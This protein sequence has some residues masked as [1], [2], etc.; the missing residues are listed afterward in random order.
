MKKKETDTASAAFVAGAGG[1][2]GSGPEAPKLI[3]LAE[4]GR[5]LGVDPT[6]VLRWAKAGRGGLRAFQF[7]GRLC[8]WKV[9]ADDVA[10]FLRESGAMGD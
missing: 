5:L 1:R 4:A 3:G 9:R 2:V 10:R 8:R 7:G 6:T